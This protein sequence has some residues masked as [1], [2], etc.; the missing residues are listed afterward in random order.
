[1]AEEVLHVEFPRTGSYRPGSKRVPEPVRIH[2]PHPGLQPMPREHHV[3]VVIAQGPAVHRLEQRPVRPAPVSVQISSKGFE[4]HITDG[5]PALLPAPPL[6]NPNRM[7]VQEDVVEVYR[8]Q[9][10]RAD[11]RIQ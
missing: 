10:A 3:H 1:M 11:P 6:Q 4:R 5:R 2:L 7:L 8:D 9:L